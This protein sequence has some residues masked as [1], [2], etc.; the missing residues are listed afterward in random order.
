[1]KE[2]KI[3]RRAALAAAGLGVAAQA[4]AQGSEYPNRPIRM[5]IPFLI[6]MVKWNCENKST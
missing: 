5:V 2:I 6:L 4:R 1:M 3:G